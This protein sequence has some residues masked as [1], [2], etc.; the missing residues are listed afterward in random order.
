MPKRI[1]RTKRPRDVNQLAH[2]LGRMSTH[3]NEGSN[4]AQKTTGG[5]Q[6]SPEEQERQTVRRIMAEMGRR[7]GR[8]GGKR[9]LETMTPE[10]RSELAYN[11]AKA[12]WGPKKNGN[13]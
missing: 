4:L 12:R 7:G 11:A 5:Q 1:R 10:R 6:L 8:I 13:R 9:R 3:Q 2:H